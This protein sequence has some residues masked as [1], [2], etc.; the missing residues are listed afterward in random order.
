MATQ[1]C[2][3]W[4]CRVPEDYEV[5]VLRVLEHLE[6]SADGW[7][8]LVRRK[9]AGW[10]ISCWTQLDDYFDDHLMWDSYAGGSLGV[11]ITV[12]YG[13]LKHSLAKSAG[14]LD[15]DGVP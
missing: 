8:S 6:I 11:G 12:R 4:E 2:D 10:N 5:A 14:Q 7:T 13:V 15:L 9:A 1:F 3:P